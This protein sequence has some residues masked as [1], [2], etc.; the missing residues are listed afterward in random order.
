M[1][2]LL[3]GVLLPSGKRVSNRYEPDDT[4]QDDYHDEWDD[5]VE[6]D[7]GVYCPHCQ[8]YHEQDELPPNIA[9]VDIHTPTLMNIPRNIPISIDGHLYVKGDLSPECAHPLCNASPTHY[10]EVNLHPDEDPDST[11]AYSVTLGIGLCL[12]HLQ[13]PKEDIFNKCT[14]HFAA[15]GVRS[16]T[17]DMLRVKYRMIGDE[18]W[19]EYLQHV[20]MSNCGGRA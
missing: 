2:G 18:S 6:P 1:L 19:Q 13:V 16:L 17:E 7:T 8:G 4:Y 3:I 9:P 12:Q 10:I 11:P 14:N 15:L 5:E 20:A